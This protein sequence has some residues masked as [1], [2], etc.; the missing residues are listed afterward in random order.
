MGLLY[1][2]TQL[3]VILFQNLS[4]ADATN[5]HRSFVILRTRARTPIHTTSFREE[6]W[7]PVTGAIPAGESFPAVTDVSV[8]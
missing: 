3:K 2:W 7:G 1:P 5:V 4:D 6:Q 8:L